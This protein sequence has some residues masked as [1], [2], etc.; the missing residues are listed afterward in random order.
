MPNAFFRLIF[1][2]IL[3]LCSEISSLAESS[4]VLSKAQ[5]LTITNIV[6]EGNKRTDKETL[7]DY[8][9]IEKSGSYS[10]TDLDDYLK[11]LF[12]T[13][14]FSDVVLEI[15]GSTLIVKIKE[16]KCF[17]QIVFEGNEAASDEDLDTAVRLK[18]REI[19]TSVRVQEAVQNMRALYRVKGRFATKITPKIIEKEQNRVDLIFEIEE[20]PK[21]YVREIYFVGN[22]CFDD[23][24]LNSVISTKEYSWYR[25]FSADDVYDS[26]R[27]RYDGELLRQF[28]LKNGYADFKIIASNAELSPDNCDFFITFTVDEGLRYR[29]GTTNIISEVSGICIASLKKEI[30][31]SKGEWFNQKEAQNVSDEISKQLNIQ[32][33]PF[34]EILIEPEKN[35]KDRIIDI[36]FVIKKTAPAYVNNITIKGNLGTDQTV[37][38]REL[39]FSSGDAINPA[40]ISES[41]KNLSNTDY[42]ESVDIAEKEV[43]S[44]F[45]RDIEVTVKE[46]STG[47]IQ[48]GAGYSTIEG[49][50]GKI[51]YNERNFLGKGQILN[52]SGYFSKRNLDVDI[53]FADPFFL[54][55]RLMA[56]VDV[57]H[58][59]YRGDTRGTFESGGYKQLS[60]GTVLHMGY[61]LRPRL[62]QRWHYKVKRDHV[63]LR[64]SN[65]TSPFLRLKYPTC[66]VSSIGHDLIYDK[67]KILA[68]EPAGGYILKLNTEF[69]G[70]GGTIKFLANTLSAHQYFPL[71]E[72]QKWI[73]RCEARYGA[74]I[75]MG[76]MR[77]LD[78][79]NLGGTDFGGF[80]QSGIGPKD[81]RTSDSLGGRQFYTAALKLYFP[82]GL[83][84]EFP[85]KGITYLQTGS[86]WQ[87]GLKSPFIVSNT[88]APRLSAGGG[89]I[90]NSPLGKIGCLLSK[91]ILKRSHDETQTFLFLWGQD[92]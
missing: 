71:D 7:L 27:V 12:N 89:V 33:F 72:D 46:K 28:Y 26:E 75:K 68:G 63:N 13:G 21:T 36:K 32:G 9:P 14:L 44:P 69:A 15:K 70:V 91:A 58:S 17:N 66:Y 23:N 34:V 6:I 30:S 81:S 25:F 20:G 5:Q 50:V 29:F 86:L 79:F 92:F 1:L 78:R 90:W 74:L 18:P 61:E 76:Y 62:F 88:F 87:S 65:H 83:P 56:G 19:Y 10:R 82:L 67:S 3:I 73:L 35:T 40:K 16:N 53:G 47:D 80:G 64:D 57:F 41:E 84:K 31:W 52:L 59:A 77:F 48:F 55:R 51:G 42:F 24:T 22:K 60:T 2:G 11:K 37:I 54:G 4:S 8:F 49:P 85:I 39:D 43:C 38:L 45:Q